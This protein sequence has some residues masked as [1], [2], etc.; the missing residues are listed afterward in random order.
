MSSACVQQLGPHEKA[1]D[2]LEPEQQAS[3]K[4]TMAPHSARLFR[5]PES[6]G[7]RV[8][9]LLCFSEKPGTSAFTYLIC[10]RR[11][12]EQTSLPGAEE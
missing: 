10:K 5:T 11:A 7:A 1:L 8:K 3:R 2:F 12:G 9:A 6:S 4:A